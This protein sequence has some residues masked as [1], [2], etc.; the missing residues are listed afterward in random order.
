MSVQSGPCNWPTLSQFSVAS[1]GSC[2][3][4]WSSFSG[5]LQEQSLEFA[6]TIV[7]AATGRQFGLCELTVRPCRREC[8]GC[9]AGYYWDG[10][11]TWTPYIWNGSWHNCWCGSDAGCCTCDPNCQVYLP[12]PVD[13]ILTVQVDGVS[14]P[15][16]G[17]YF[18]LDQQWLVRVD[19]EAC[20]PT[21]SDQNLA[22]GDPEAFEV[23]YLRGRDVPTA[24]AGATFLLACEYA[25]AC[26]G[27]P[28]RLPG[29]V[30]SIARQGITI[31][32][33]DVNETLKHGLTG[34]WELDQL[35]MAYN[36]YGLKGKTRMYSPDMVPPRQVTWP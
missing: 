18:V 33:A 1:S 31:S 12:G 20:W 3:T 27:L 23:T 14:L 11:G 32:L 4:D 30:Q 28:C 7:W 25:K 15:P 29:R 16:T 2:C 19:T 35:I 8:Q 5:P 36:P 9:P 24:L 17:S 21:C 22:P 34:I 13:S 26:A 6:K 10:Y